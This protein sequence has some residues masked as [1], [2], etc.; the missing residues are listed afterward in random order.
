MSDWENK[1]FRESIVRDHELYLVTGQ[2]AKFKTLFEVIR[3]IVWDDANIVFEKNS[4]SMIK[5]NSNKKAML[6]LKLEPDF[7]EYYHTEFDRN[8]VGINCV[9]FYKIIKTAKNNDDTISLYIKKNQKKRCLVIKIENLDKKTVSEDEFVIRDM[10]EDPCIMPSEVAYPGSII[11]P[12]ASFQNI[13]K[14]IK[15][16]AAKRTNKIVTIEHIG[17]QLIFKYEGEISKQKL[18]LGHSKISK[19][20]KDLYNT[21]DIKDLKNLSEKLIAE[22]NIESE[23]ISGTY[24]LDYLIIFAKAASLDSTM[25][26]RIQNELPLILEYKVGVLGRL[27]LLLNTIDENEI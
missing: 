3:D 5:E 12:S 10:N 25:L 16:K 14:N 13:F 22:E 9:N 6:H 7:F 23:I 11:T 2:I 20:A 1:E 24:D 4:I 8:I 15:S 17:D 27:H 21:L 19:L 18:V 26:I